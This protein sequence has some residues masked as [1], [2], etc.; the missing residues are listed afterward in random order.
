MALL[1]LFV[2]RLCL[3][4]LEQ[5][6]FSND[7]WMVFSSVIFISVALGISHRVHMI[8]GR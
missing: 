5:L 3:K 4:Q 8:T 6:Q 1:L 7:D 2:A